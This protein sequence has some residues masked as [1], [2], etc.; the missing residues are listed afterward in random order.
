MA[1]IVNMHEAKTT[2][3]QL[4]DRAEAG[5]DIVLARAG[6]PVVRLVPI[7]FARRRRLGQWKGKV[8]MAR[9]FDEPLTDEQ[10][11]AWLGADKKP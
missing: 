8:S 11:A 6:S 5:E 3:S 4:V 10:L 9:D 1:R 2:L 7:R